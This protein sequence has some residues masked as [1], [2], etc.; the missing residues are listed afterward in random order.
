[1]GPTKIG[2]Q[3]DQKLKSKFE[4][5]KR[6]DAD[7]EH[8]GHKEQEENVKPGRTL[9]PQISGPEIQFI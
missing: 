8:D 6:G 3:I 7:A 5:E 2:V 4:P 9:C 1:M